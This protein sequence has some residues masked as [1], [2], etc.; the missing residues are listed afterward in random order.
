M[1]Y[2]ILENKKHN[3]NYKLI[4]VTIYDGNRFITYV[5][6]I[7]NDGENAGLELY[8]KKE[9]YG[10]FYNSRRYL[11]SEIPEKHKS[12]YT[13]LSRI[14]KDCNSGYKI[15]IAPDGLFYNLLYKQWEQTI[16]QPT[17]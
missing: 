1:N 10:H 14:F 7:D 15:T 13:Y 4:E 12:F 9:K 6:G 16:K 8:F 17:Q 11:I 2:T 5:A 3:P